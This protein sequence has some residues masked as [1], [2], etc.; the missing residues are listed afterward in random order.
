MLDRRLEIVW[1]RRIKDIDDDDD[2]LRGLGR[3]EGT[4]LAGNSRKNHNFS[5]SSY[6][7]KN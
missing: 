6:L 7:K 4:R 5:C 3:G 2:G 1:S